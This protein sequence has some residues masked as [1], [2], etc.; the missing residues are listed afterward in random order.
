MDFDYH[1]PYTGTRLPLFARNVV[2]TSHP[3]GAQAGLRML[4]Q[5]GN[6]VDAAVAAAAAM[7][8]LEPVSNGL[9]SDAFCI[10]WDGQALHGLNASGRAPQAWT[11]DYFRARYGA[12]AMAPPKRGIDSVTVPGAVSSWVALS[13]R[14]GKLPF[15][16]LMGP[17]IELAERGYGVPTVVQQK[18][19]AAVQELHA[20]PGFA[21][22]FLPRGRA[23]L[24]GE[25]F[26]FKAA[27]RALRAIAATKGEAFYTGEIADAI[28]KFSARLGGSLTRHDLAAHRPDWVLP[29]A[30]NYRGY[31]LHEIAPNGQ[32]IA[33]LIALGILDQFDLRQLPVDGVDS[34]HLQI[35]AMK[36]A[37]ADVYQ[38]V[39]DPAS[40]GVTAQQMLDDSYLAARAQL[41]DRG[42]AQDFK[43]GS[44]NDA[45]RRGGTIYLS[46][47]D[48]SGMMVSFIQSNYM[49]FGSGCVE[50]DF[51]ISLQ[52]RGHGFSLNPAS[53][54]VV[55][56]AKRPF[57]TI[58]PAFLT[59]DGQPVMS[60]GVMGANMQPQ[61][62]LQTLARMLDYGQNP[63]AACDAPRWRFNAGLEINV[64]ASMNPATVQ[65][66]SERG[67]HMAVIQ[68]SYQDFGAGQFIWRAGDPG[69]QGYVAASDARRDGQAVGF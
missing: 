51:G 17:A 56:S 67:H 1:N 59:R 57:H 62:H 60:F 32:G 22:A 50:P 38:F 39:A 16:D 14:F 48:E 23:P 29:I 46:A 26:Q 61:G 28:A 55:A 19:A 11:P 52:N 53:P 3:L 42:R 9:G 30:K 63:Q 8:V 35:E 6:A 10:L 20:L 34:Q 54:N 49:G 21:Q 18:W 33:A 68:D 45:H 7:T 37:F 65:G 69:S 66:L 5:G 41:I 13:E 44:P 24:V 58:I 40:M 12:G 43:A 15:A 4:L 36:L 31:T 25:L 64:E 27:A 47:A 2:S